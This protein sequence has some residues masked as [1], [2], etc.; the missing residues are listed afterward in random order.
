MKNNKNL[1]I[2][3]LIVIIIVILFFY[4]FTNEGV[5]R[6]L[7]DDD[8]KIISASWDNYAEEYNSVSKRWETTDEEIDWDFLCG[9]EPFE[10]KSVSYTLV[11]QQKYDLSCY[12]IIN[13]EVKEDYYTALDGSRIRT[14]HSFGQEEK[15]RSGSYNLDY[16][17]NNE[18]GICCTAG[19]TREDTSEV[20]KSITLPVKC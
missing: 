9:N 7:T 3:T 8:F 15:T 13:G 19:F 16:T 11:T 6:H 1:V 20:C 18:I 12:Y 14:F 10:T 17:T 4:V 2:G 5:E